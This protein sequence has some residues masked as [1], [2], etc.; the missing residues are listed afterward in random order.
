MRGLSSVIRRGVDISRSVWYM[1]FPYRDAGRDARV[2]TGV[3]RALHRKQ[4][5]GDGR[6]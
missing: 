6:G 5:E 1:A 3:L 2:E 4:E